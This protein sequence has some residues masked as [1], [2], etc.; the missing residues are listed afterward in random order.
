MK[1]LK[2][3]TGSPDLSFSLPD[4]ACHLP[5]FS[6]VPTDPEPGELSHQVPCGTKGSYNAVPMDSV[7]ACSF[8]VVQVML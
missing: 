7:Y 2:L 1:I 5:A 8:A 3:F 6:I 4:H